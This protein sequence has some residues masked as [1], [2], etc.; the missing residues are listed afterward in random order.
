MS[1]LCEICGDLPATVPDRERIGRPINRVCSRC[2]R[3]RLAGDLEL[4]L[5][6]IRKKT[7]KLAEEQ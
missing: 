5:E 4:I 3:L 7:A 2:H 1:K 6:L